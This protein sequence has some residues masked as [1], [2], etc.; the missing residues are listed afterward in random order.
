[1]ASFSAFGRTV[2]SRPGRRGLIKGKEGE[3][4][5]RSRKGDRE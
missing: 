2:L 3:V 1:M 4:E 5:R